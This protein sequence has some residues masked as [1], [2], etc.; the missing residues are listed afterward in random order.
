MGNRYLF[1]KPKST[2]ARNAVIASAVVAAVAFGVFMNLSDEE[3]QDNTN[4]IANAGA[5]VQDKDTDENNA[6]E[7]N[8][9][10]IEKEDKNDVVTKG[11]EAY[12]LLKEAEGQIE[13]Y[14]YDENGKEKFIRMTDIPFSLISNS[15]QELFRQGVVVKSESELDSIL[16]DFES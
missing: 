7:R 16:Q 3:V 14:Y 8:S 5:P 10:K 2:G 11:E 15:D 6:D 9:D 13:L 12:Y 1:G 4:L